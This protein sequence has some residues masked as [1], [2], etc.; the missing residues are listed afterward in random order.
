MRL[1]TLPEAYGII[2][3]YIEENNLEIIE[4]PRERYIDDIWNKEKPK[5]WLTEIQI[6]IKNKN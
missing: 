4:S 6:P 2:M 1:S 5:D 3:K